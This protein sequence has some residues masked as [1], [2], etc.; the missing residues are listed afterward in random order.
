MEQ[1]LRRHVEEIMRSSRKDREAMI[2][3]AKAAL[4][5]SRLAG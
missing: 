3:T 4:G 1:A 5:H 2:D